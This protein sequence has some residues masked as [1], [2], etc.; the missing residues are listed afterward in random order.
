M[1]QSHALRNVHLQ[2]INLHRS[3]CLVWVLRPWCV[4]LIPILIGQ[5]EVNTHDGLPV[6]HT[7]S[8]QRQTTIHTHIHPYGQIR[9]SN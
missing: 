1:F 5:V 2:E 8:T 7:A 3:C 6:Y 9:V 4:L